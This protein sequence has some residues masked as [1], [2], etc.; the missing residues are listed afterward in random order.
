MENQILYPHCMK[1]ISN[2]SVIDSTAKGEDHESAFTIAAVAKRSHFGHYS[3]ADK[4]D[5][6]CYNYQLLVL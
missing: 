1:T 3:P 5:K 4:S 6:T 2:N